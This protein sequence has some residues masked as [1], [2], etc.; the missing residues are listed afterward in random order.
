LNSVNNG[1]YGQYHAHMVA[2]EFS[3]A[4]EVMRR[5]RHEARAR[6]QKDEAALFGTLMASAL[7]LAGSLQAAESAYRDAEADDP[8]NALLKL[9]LAN[10]LLDALNQPESALQEIEEA[11]PKLSADRS[12]YHAVVSSLGTIYVSLGR[13]EDATRTF[14]ELVPTE[15]LPGAEPR[16]Y[17]FRFVTAL[18]ARGVML[19]ECQG[20]AERVLA[21]AVRQDDDDT[22]RT[23]RT[24]ID[25]IR[26]GQ[27]RNP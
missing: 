10:F 12:T 17:D 13:M 11:L 25:S 4:A 23:A 26:R 14:H 2:R 21:L 20:Y 27:P 15:A 18:V 24:V 6:D 8:S 19:E 9:Q 1:L 7:A 3:D 16:A 22:A 5:A